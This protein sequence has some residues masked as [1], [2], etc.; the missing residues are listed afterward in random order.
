MVA[1]EGLLNRHFYVLPI[2]P[3]KILL[4]YKRIYW[5]LDYK[6]ADRPLITKSKLFKQNLNVLN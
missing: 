4:E 3:N 6:M 1:T 2:K 5:T